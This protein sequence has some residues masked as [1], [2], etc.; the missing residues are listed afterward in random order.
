M[1]E[2]W[3]EG[4]YLGR[5]F[6]TYEAVVMQ[7]SDG[8]MVSMGLIQRLEREVTMEMLNKLVGVPWDPAGV[9][10]VR[11]DGGHHDGEHVRVQTR[12]VCQ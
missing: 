11:A 6:H 10:G 9:I 7:L 8:V 1:S 3:F 2:R 4:L 5:T 12:M